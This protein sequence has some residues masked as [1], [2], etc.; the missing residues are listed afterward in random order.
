MV[1][2]DNWLFSHF[3]SKPKFFDMDM[4]DV[5]ENKN[6]IKAQRAALVPTKVV[7]KPDGSSDC[8]D[9]DEFEML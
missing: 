2:K 1:H 8:S 7:I 6:D 5:P 3:E 9:D 4:F